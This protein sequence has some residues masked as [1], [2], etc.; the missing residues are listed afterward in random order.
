MTLGLPGGMVVT[1]VHTSLPSIPSLGPLAISKQ[2]SSLQL[3][4]CPLESLPGRLIPV[5]GVVA[6][7]S[8]VS[9]MGPKEPLPGRLP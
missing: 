9:L 4:P 2:T 6:P 8:D 1:S 7:S 5:G 3:N